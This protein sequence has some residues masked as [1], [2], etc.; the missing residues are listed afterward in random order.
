MNGLKST[1]WDVPSLK[2]IFRVR[3]S[4]YSAQTICSSSGI[5]VIVILFSVESPSGFAD[6]ALEVVDAGLGQT[7]AEVVWVEVRTDPVE[8]VFEVNV[9]WAVDGFE[10]FDVAACAPDVVWRTCAFS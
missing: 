9:C 6:G 4:T 3:Y 7:M 8:C 1:V 10:E 2:K 5:I